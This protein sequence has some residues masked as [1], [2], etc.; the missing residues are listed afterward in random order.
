MQRINNDGVP[1]V[2]VVAW[3]DQEIVK[4]GYTTNERWKPFVARGGVVLKIERYTTGAEALQRER[5]LENA[6]MAEF[7]RA[8]MEK[9]QALPLLGSG[10]AG[11]SE[12]YRATAE[13]AQ[14]V[15]NG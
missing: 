1:T 15:I 7:E 12:C 9:S 3:P 13:E 2:Y 8:F 11:Y 14:V 5:Y 10:G 4:A 6:L